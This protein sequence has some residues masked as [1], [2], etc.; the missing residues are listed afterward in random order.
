MIDAVAGMSLLTE[1]RLETQGRSMNI[2]DKD[3]DQP[4]LVD[5][6]ESTDMT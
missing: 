1:W 3:S 6:G 2:N 5:L 4:M